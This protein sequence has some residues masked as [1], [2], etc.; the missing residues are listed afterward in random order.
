MKNYRALA[1]LLIT[2]FLGIHFTAHTGELASQ[3]LPSQ[4][5]SIFHSLPAEIRR[6]I[7]FLAL[8]LAKQYGDYEYTKT[9]VKL[10]NYC[11][12][13]LSM[14]FSHDGTTLFVNTRS[15]NKNES[16]VRLLVCDLERETEREFGAPVG[17]SSEMM[18][19]PCGSFL[20]LLGKF[21]FGISRWN[22]AMDTC[23]DQMYTDDTRYTKGLSP[24]GTMLFTELNK[25][26]DAFD[27]DRLGYLWNTQTGERITEFEEIKKAAEEGCLL[28]V[29][30]KNPAATK[31]KASLL[32][33]K[34]KELIVELKE[35]HQTAHALAF[36]PDKKTIAVFTKDK[37]ES[38]SLERL[39]LWSTETGKLIYTLKKEEGYIPYYREIRQGLYTK[40]PVLDTPKCPMFGNSLMFSP[41]GTLLMVRYMINEEP[42]QNRSGKICLWHVKTGKLLREFTI[43]G[44]IRYCY[45]S[46]DGDTIVIHESGNKSDKYY[47]RIYL[48]DIHENRKIGKLRTQ[49]RISDLVEITPQGNLF[50]GVE[51]KSTEDLY[52][53][54][55]QLW[56]RPQAESTFQL[57]KKLYP[58][59]HLTPLNEPSAI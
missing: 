1:L 38:P 44:F 49:Q 46:P 2:A 23:V 45:F 24:D 18:L 3:T 5:E 59:F 27:P 16:T 57:F 9:V 34:T 19:S 12:H 26:N 8:A 13:S 52:N 22:I 15:S 33:P 11:S 41:G 42:F 40:R 55:I 56:S 17:P 7:V 28:R 6:H 53:G 25:E 21:S 30:V 58:L 29:Q 37:D 54:E 43:K 20:T 35:Y 4:E 50:M 14:L 31:N 47:S 51:R 36:S 32:D 48:W 39:S 10:Q